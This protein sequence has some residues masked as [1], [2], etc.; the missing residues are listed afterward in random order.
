VIGRDSFFSI[1]DCFKNFL[2]D[3]CRSNQVL[4]SKEEFGWS[5]NLVTFEESNNSF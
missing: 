2:F 5:F 3:Y 1:G 4:E